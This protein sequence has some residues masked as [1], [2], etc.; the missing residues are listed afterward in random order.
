MSTQE[1]LKHFLRLLGHSTWHRASS[2]EQARQDS[3]V[4]HYQATE[5]TIVDPTI[6][7]F[8]VAMEQ[9]VGL[10]PV[11]VRISDEAEQ[12]LTELSMSHCFER[13]KV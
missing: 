4:G 8:I 13:P 7:V 12:C 9:Q 10:L 2:T 3:V 5:L 11:V 1:S 6:H